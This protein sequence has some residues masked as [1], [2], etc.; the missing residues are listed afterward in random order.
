MALDTSLSTLAKLTNDVAKAGGAA[1]SLRKGRRGSGRYGRRPDFTAIA[2]PSSRPD[3][4]AGV[5]FHFKH[6]FVSKKNSIS[7]GYRDLTSAA[8]HQR[9]IER[10]GAAERVSEGG[11][12]REISFGN[13]GDTKEERAEFWRK[14]EEVESKAGRVQCR[15]I[16]ELPHELSPE[17]REKAARAFMQNLVDR[18]FPCWAVIHAPDEHNDRRNYHLHAVYYDRPCLRLPDGRWDF[19]LKTEVLWKNGQRASKRPLKQPKDTTARGKEWIRH[20]R[21]DWAENANAVLQEE[22]LSKR[23]DPRPYRESGVRKTPTAHLGNKIALAESQGIDTKIGTEN[24]RREMRFRLSRPDAGFDRISASLDAAISGIRLAAQNGGNPGQSRGDPRL[25]MMASLACRRILSAGLKSAKAREANALAVDV[26][27]A[28]LARR[29]GFLDAEYD[30][31]TL[32]PPRWLGEEDALAIA[33]SLWDER[34]LID[35]ASADLSP[36]RASCRAAAVAHDAEA[37]KLDQARRGAV[38]AMLKAMPQL[39]QMLRAEEIEALTLPLSDA[40]LATLEATSL[41][42]RLAERTH[43][44]VS[45]QPATGV[46]SVE[47]AARRQ[48]ADQSEDQAAAKSAEPATQPTASAPASRNVAADPKPGSRAARTKGETAERTSDGGTQ[49]GLA[50]H[51]LETNL[52]ASDRADPAQDARRDPGEPMAGRTAQ[53]TIETAKGE[54]SAGAIQMGEIPGALVLADPAARPELEKTLAATPGWQLRYHYL[55]T[56]DAAD[57]SDDEAVVRRHE[58]A[59][60]IVEKEAARRGL[61]LETGR[62]DPARARDARAFE[63]HRG[64]WQPLPDDPELV[65]QIED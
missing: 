52:S 4:G 6:S 56:R 58:Q 37:A 22:G 35:D 50:D 24:S 28:R 48:A 65:R 47:A 13:L 23:Y 33:A 60:A 1:P 15:M 32:A 7:S 5:T 19:E 25:A 63:R 8:A 39:R 53:T 3:S 21:N 31:L 61:D 2:A 20:L 10:A 9:Y 30:R 38:A 43:T 34:R 62:M 16:V 45:V 49:R 26:I 11:F 57:F 42:E 54:P 27:G 40:P 17:G 44:G 46:A 12:E 41:D 51:L 36:F 18:G 29:A 55:A 64:D 14:V 59:L